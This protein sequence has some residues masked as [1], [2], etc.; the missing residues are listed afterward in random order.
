MIIIPK[1]MEEAVKL[2]WDI[3]EQGD[4]RYNESEAE[5]ILSSFLFNQAILLE[6]K[7]FPNIGKPKREDLFKHFIQGQEKYIAK[8]LL[9]LDGFNN[10]EI[11]YERMFLDSRPD[12]FAEKQDKKIIVECCS[13]RVSKVINFL[14]EADE[15]WIL[16]SGE[17]PWEEKP[18]FE[19]IQWFVFKKGSKWN[20][21]YTEF[22]QKQ[23]EQ[24]KKASTAINKLK[25]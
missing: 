13:C 25:L 7:P 17:N 6:E 1:T 22:K 8:I 15:L 9:N 20:K 2:V 10:D 5:R 4:S 3:L 19:K 14:S 12:V 18:L 11:F 23:I 21:V 24:L 16:T